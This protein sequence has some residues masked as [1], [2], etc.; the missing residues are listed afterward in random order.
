MNLEKDERFMCVW[1]LYS[2]SRWSGR[3][4]GKVWNKPA[5][6][7]NSLKRLRNNI[8]IKV[9]F[10]RSDV[11]FDSPVP[12][13]VNNSADNFTIEKHLSVVAKEKLGAMDLKC[14]SRSEAN[15]GLTI[16]QP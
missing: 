15:P 10:A 1:L 6:S 7:L 16:S 11:K 12:V 8:R 9:L 3:K 13:E 5:L 2:S 4:E 14:V